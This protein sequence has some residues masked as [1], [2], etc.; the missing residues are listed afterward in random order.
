M[1]FCRSGKLYLSTCGRSSTKRPSCDGPGLTIFCRRVVVD[2]DLPTYLRFC[3]GSR[4]AIDVMLYIIYLRDL[5][6][7]IGLNTK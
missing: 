2:T 7:E 4:A 6:Q 5:D 1:D 3:T